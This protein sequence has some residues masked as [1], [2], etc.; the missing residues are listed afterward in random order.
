MARFVTNLRLFVWVFFFATQIAEHDVVPVVGDPKRTD[1]DEKSISDHTLL[2]VL[3]HLYSVF[4]VCVSNDFL[5]AS[6][7]KKLRLVCSYMT[8]QLFNGTFASIVA[9]YGVDTL[10]AALDATLSPMI[11]SDTTLSEANVVDALHGIQFLPIDHKL[12]LRLQSSV[13]QIE[14]TFPAIDETL[15]FYH[16]NLL[17][18]GVDQDCT[19]TLYR[20]LTS[21]MR[22]VPSDAVHLLELRDSA[23]FA[24]ELD[25]LKDEERG[26]R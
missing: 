1:H 16:D 10:R 7:T 5:L 21:R 19:R 12:Y 14:Q 3:R 15:L 20:Y 9:T 8:T 4:K 13:N 24:S 11:A 17:W 26:D 6:E 25:A 2:P 23:L 18:S 22:V